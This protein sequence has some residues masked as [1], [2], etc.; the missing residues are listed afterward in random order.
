M[1]QQCNGHY[2]R[3]VFATCIALQLINLSTSVQVD[4]KDNQVEENVNYSYSVWI[5]SHTSEEFSILL[6]SPK[7]TSFCDAMNQAAQIDSRFDFKYKNTSWGH[8]ITEID[9]KEESV[10]NNIFWMLYDLP[11]FPNK[12]KKP[13]NEY[14]SPVGVDGLIVENDKHYLFWLKEVNL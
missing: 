6:S 4:S 10:K 12:N 11:Q 8:Y 2:W 3:W 1:T 14:L 7:N 9:G 5:G 13:G